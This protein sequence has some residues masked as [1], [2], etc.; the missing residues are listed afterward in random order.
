MTRI[1]VGIDPS[2]LCDQMLLAELRELPRCYSHRTDGGPAQFTLGKGHVLWCARYQLSLLTRHAKL[3]TECRRRGF[4]VSAPSMEYT[5]PGEW[6]ATSEAIASP[7]LIARISERLTQM[8]RTPRWTNATPP[9][10]A[11]KALEARHAHA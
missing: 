1:N 10:W 4:N 8:K 6:S 5:G 11:Q 3:Y 7:L 2:E 9:E